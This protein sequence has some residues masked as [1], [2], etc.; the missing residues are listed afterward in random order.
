MVARVETDVLPTLAELDIGF[1]PFSP[2][3]KGCLTGALNE[4]TSFYST[5][6]RN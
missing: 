2:L 1:V 3:G 4:H 5:D 6:C